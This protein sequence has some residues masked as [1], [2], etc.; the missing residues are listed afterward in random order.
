M[1]FGGHRSVVRFHHPVHFKNF[2]IA[3]SALAVVGSLA[4]LIWRLGLKPLYRDLWSR[5]WWRLT[6]EVT[7]TLNDMNRWATKQGSCGFIPAGCLN[8]RQDSVSFK[9]LVKGSGAIG[10]CSMR[11]KWG[12]D[13]FAFWI[14]SETYT[15][16]N[17]PIILILITK[18][19]KIVAERPL[20]IGYHVMR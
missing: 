8:G 18:C 12:C 1:P 3:R 17:K 9:T 6:Q 13:T 15:S 10:R 19:R 16:C 4:R 11:G 14:G 2:D 5:D 20:L 7:A